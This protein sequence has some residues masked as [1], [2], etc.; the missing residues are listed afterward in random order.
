MKRPK[1][2]CMHGLVTLIQK[3]N[4]SF[5]YMLEKKTQI[6]C[7]NKWKRYSYFLVNFLMT[8]DLCKKTKIPQTAKSLSFFKKGKNIIIILQ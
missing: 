8:N 2:N 6:L 4:M 3:V 5:Y 7:Y 1:N